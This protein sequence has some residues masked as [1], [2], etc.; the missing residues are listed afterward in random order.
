M[1]TND[2][3][4][5]DGSPL[6]P[7]DTHVESFLT[8][9]HAAGYAGR[10]VRLK[11]S[12]AASFARWTM[13]EQV[14]VDDL[15]ESH[16]VA[17][18]GRS[19]RRGKAQV[20]FELAT[21]RSFLQHLR[22]EAGVQIPALPIEPS[23][24]EE[25]RCRYVDYLRSERGLAENSIRVYSPYI[26][27]FL[28]QLASGSGSISPAGLEALTVQDY[29][30]HDIRG[31]SSE[32]SRLLA[33][34]LRSF[35]RFLFL[36]GETA[37]DLSPS[38]PMVRRWRQGTV[39]TFISSEEVERAL[40][41]PDQSTPG[42]LRDHAI[43]LLLARL[44]LRAGEVVALELSDIRWRA[45]EIVVRGKGRVLD[46]LPLLSEVGEA[47]AAYLRSGRGKSESRRVFLRTWAPRIGLAGHA[48][49]T[50]IVRK[51]LAKAEVHPPKRIA[52]HLFR[53]SLA[54][55]MIRN[56]ASMAEISEVLRHR[57]QNSTAIYAKVAFES[58][59][60]V[61][62]AWPATGGER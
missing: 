28:R 59:R 16:I 27:D 37:I 61:A 25:L 49:V 33:T 19:P 50:H 54:T 62:R 31:R 18:V 42:G 9:F 34:A 11:R 52:A 45:G 39:P 15:N 44:G 13:H 32:Y 2:F 41:A 22:A 14:A 23:P 1:T 35:L 20:R 29:L 26:R 43:L 38:V 55:R 12:I 48:A 30:L 58:L 4:G 6:G 47:L 5:S 51:A 21:L 46:R 40:S 60:G 3:P 10:T 57:S 24:A 36:R 56:G 17:F 8:H 7:V 53:H